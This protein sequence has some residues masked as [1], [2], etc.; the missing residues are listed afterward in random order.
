MTINGLG[1]AFDVCSGVVPKDFGSSAQTGHRLHMKNYGGVAIVLFLDNGTAAENPTLTVQEHTAAS[2]G[3]STNLV[4]IDTYY[5]K[6]EAQLD[7]DETWTKGTQTAA[8][9]LTDADWDDALEVLAVVEVQANELSDGYEWISANLDA[10]GTAH[11]GG[12]LYIPYDLDVQRK[13]ENLEAPN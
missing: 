12:I 2:G 7:G 13:P 8:A 10:P 3:T 1:R 6:T 9:T 4:V 5:T 11:V